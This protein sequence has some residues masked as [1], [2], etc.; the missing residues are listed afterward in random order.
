[1]IPPIWFL[2]IDRINIKLGRQ[3][4]NQ[5]EGEALEILIGKGLISRAHLNDKTVC[6]TSLIVVFSLYKIKT[7]LFKIENK[8]RITNSIEFSSATGEIMKRESLHD[9]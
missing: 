3:P 8:K 5:T 1:M 4:L 2:E 6:F 7:I 9:A